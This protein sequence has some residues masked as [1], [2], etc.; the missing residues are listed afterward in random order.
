MRADGMDA[1]IDTGTVPALQGG[2]IGPN[3]ITRAAEALRDEVGA[4]GLA[5]L[6][7]RAGL[8]A[9]L[10]APPEHMVREDEV[11]RLHHVIYER[12][13]PERARKV[14]RAAGERTGAYLLR[15]RIPG[16]ARLA[17]RLLPAPLASRALV[18]AIERHSWT[19]AGT[20][21]FSASGKGPVRFTLTDCPLCR[22]ARA[23]LPRCDFYAACFEQ[24]FRALVH[25]RAAVTETSCAATGADACRFEVTW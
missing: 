24:L 8:S 25:R 20:A 22:G 2:L 14:A 6:F 13:G 21:A 9:Y 17:L 5:E 19:F 1:A 10:Q 18:A 4:D 12:L 3:A 16:P 15:C 7:G 23:P 11:T